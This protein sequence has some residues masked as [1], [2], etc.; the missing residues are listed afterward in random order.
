LGYSLTDDFFNCWLCGFVKHYDAISLLT[1]KKEIV[2]IQKVRSKPR[3][4]TKT[5]EPLTL[6]KGLQELQIQHERYLQK[7]GFDPEE[8]KFIWKVKATT[9]N[10]EIPWSIWIPINPTGELLSWTARRITDTEKDKY[11]HAPNT[12]KGQLLYG[13]NYATSSV[14]VVEGPLDVWRVG[15]GSVATLGLKHTEEQMIQIGKYPRR[16]IL[17]DNS[18]EAQRRAFKLCKNLQTFPGETLRV[19]I[20]SPDPGSATPKEI[21]K[22]RKLMREA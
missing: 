7:R 2:R 3:K 20:D 9:L 14:I 1:G 10:R 22:I 19:E 8:I 5:K 18:L 21:R 6:P 4:I 17:F 11:R 13:S 12:E 16:I 15:M